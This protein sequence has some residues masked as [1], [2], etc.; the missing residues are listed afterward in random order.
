ML[1]RYVSILVFFVSPV[2]AEHG[3]S[4]EYTGP[5]NIDDWLPTKIGTSWEYQEI[6]RTAMGP[7]NERIEMKW[8]RKDTIV[9]NH[10][11]PQGTLIE[12]NCE[13]SKIS[14][15][16]EPDSET[17][18]FLA[19]LPAEQHFDWL[20]RKNYVF[21]LPDWAW[22]PEEKKLDDEYVRRLNDE[23]NCPDFFFPMDKAEYWSE[24]KRE[25]AELEK[26]RL[27]K[28]GKG[29]APNPARWF[30]IVVGREEVTTPAGIFPD[31]YQLKEFFNTGPVTVWFKPG[32]G[33][34]KRET[35]HSGSFQ[36]SETLLLNWK[37]G[38]T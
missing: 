38:N 23:T 35:S 9:A 34:I 36:E 28:Q 24:P 12:F 1:H 2:L 10:T 13:D 6:Y 8:T 26:A 33:V 27:W 19:R 17:K 30:W 15:A 25:R 4:L 31:S 32:V 20:I 37:F 21:V 18:Q 11:I 29:P 22:H 3:F 14:Y 16:P 5:Y 7:A